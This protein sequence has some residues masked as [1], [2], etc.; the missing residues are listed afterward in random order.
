MSSESRTIAKPFQAIAAE[1]WTAEFPP[2]RILAIRLQ[3]MGDVTITLPYLRTLQEALP[4]TEIDFLTRDEARDIPASVV[5][6]RRIYA[7]GGGRNAKRQM[8][9]AL[10]LVPSLRRRRY[11]AVIDLQNSIITKVLRRLLRTPSWSAYD[12]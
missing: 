9:L 10:A 5:L 1:P 11:N 7:L 12:P 6:F 2:R 3:A 4:G 8:A